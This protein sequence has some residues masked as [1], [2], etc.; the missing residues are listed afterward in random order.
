MKIYTYNT[1]SIAEDHKLDQLMM[2]L[3]NITWH[4]VGISETHRK[5]ED[6]LKRKVSN[7]LFYNK[8]REDKKC[9][10]VEVLANNSI[11]GNVISFDS[12]SDRVAWTKQNI[13]T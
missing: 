10:G 13:Y 8:G 5:G 11:A 2:E 7:H 4:I 9:S 1:R 6:L 3:D 12:V